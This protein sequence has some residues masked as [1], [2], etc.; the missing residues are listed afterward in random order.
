M[1]KSKLHNP[2]IAQN[3]QIEN[4]VIEKVSLANEQIFSD[5]E[6]GTPVVPEVG[7]IWFNT[8]SGTF[9]FANIGKNGDDSNYVDEFLSRTDSRTQSIVSKIDLAD[10]LTVNNQADGSAILTIDSATQN[11]SIDGA[12]SSTTL[13]GNSTETVGGDKVVDVTGTLTTEVVGNVAETFGGTKVEGITSNSTTTI[14]GT[15]IVT[16]TG[17]AT[18]TYSNV[19]ETNVT[20]NFVETV[21]GTVTISVTGDVTETFS[22]NQS[23]NITGNLNNK[24]GG[25]LKLTD[26]ANN[27]K[28][29]ANNS[30]NTLTVN[31]ATVGFNGVAET[32]TMSDKFVVNDGVNDKFVLDNTNNKLSAVYETVETTSTTA[33]DKVSGTFKLTNGTNDKIVANHTTDELNLTYTET[34]ITGNAS[35]DGNM[36]I[37]GDLTVGGQTTKVDVAAENMTIADNVVILNSNLTTEDPRLASAIVDG[38]DVDNNAGIAVNRGSQGV[39]DLVKWVESTDTANPLTLQEG[40]ARVSIWNYEAATPA[41][42]LH[43]IIDGYTL[44]RKTSGKSGTSKIGYDGEEG[45]HYVK[46]GRAHV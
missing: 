37:T 12:A 10:T 2:V 18:E 11:V 4:A 20:S 7:R 28:L 13:S 17:K 43:Q 32:H 5:L 22:G 45:T 46:I 8:D 35:V 1:I 39:L 33:T 40:T 30:I 24:V 27:L 42:E 31:Y 36:L 3:S 44:G 29:Q 25:S 41:Y 9:K 6:A 26:G 16:V 21:G 19:L 15:S 38:E 34:T 23:T 14:G